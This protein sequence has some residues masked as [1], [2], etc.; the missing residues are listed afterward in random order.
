VGLEHYSALG[1][2]NNF[3]PSAQREQSLFLVFDGKLGGT[4]VNFGVGRGWGASPDKWVV[5]AILGF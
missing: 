4:E 2:V 3:A 1:P 5:K